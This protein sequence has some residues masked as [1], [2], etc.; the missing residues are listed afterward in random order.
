MLAHPAALLHLWHF[1]YIRVTSVYLYFGIITWKHFQG[2][3]LFL[4]FQVT[5]F[6]E[7]SL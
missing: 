3:M 4:L 7:F 6:Q 5:D 2:V 1:L